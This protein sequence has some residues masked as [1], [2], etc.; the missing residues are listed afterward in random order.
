M[1]VKSE[2]L[3]ARKISFYF[4]ILCALFLALSPQFLGFVLPL[5]FIIPIFMGLF[6]I[7]HRKKSGYLIALGIVPIAFA[8]STVW[9]KYFI[10]IRGNFNTELTRISSHYSISVSTAQTLTLFFV[11]LSFVMLFVSIVVFAK[12]LKYKSIFR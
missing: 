2:A 1:S 11:A 8:I 5:L 10:S 6:G 4:T 3:I 7:K 12:L 9:I